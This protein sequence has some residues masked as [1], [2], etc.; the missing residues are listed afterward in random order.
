MNSRTSDD[1]ACDGCVTRLGLRFPVHV[2]CKF[3]PPLRGVEIVERCDLCDAFRDD[4]DAA[5][6]VSPSAR[7]VVCDEGH[8]HA[9][10]PADAAFYIRGCRYD[11]KHSPQTS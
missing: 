5:H 6:L 11:A 4:L 3:D 2:S 8:Y 10:V 7:W 1:S 9:V